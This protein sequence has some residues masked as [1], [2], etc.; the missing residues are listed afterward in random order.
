MLLD[1]LIGGKAKNT[2][3]SKH[4]EVLQAKTAA[5]DK[6]DRSEIMTTTI[7]VE[8]S[9]R[10]MPRCGDAVSGFFLFF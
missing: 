7:F 8:I 9:M 6:A 1:D 5:D 2:K 10:M 3:N 4:H